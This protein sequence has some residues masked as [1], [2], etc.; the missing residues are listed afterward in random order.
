MH[1]LQKIFY[2]NI[3]IIEQIIDYITFMFMKIKM[4]LIY[5]EEKNRFCVQ[6]HQ[7]NDDY[8]LDEELQYLDSF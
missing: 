8:D 5:I 2:E 4:I 3:F 7:K 1:L 6:G